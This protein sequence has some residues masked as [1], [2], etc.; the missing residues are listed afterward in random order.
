METVK[1]APSRLGIL[2]GTFDPIHVG[3]LVAASE[4]MHHFGL[5][6]VVLV[7]AG[8]PWQKSEFSD[9]EDRLMM[10][11][12]ASATHPRLSVSRL[13]IDRKGPTYTVDTLEALRSG[14]P[15]AELFLIVGADVAIELKTWHR[16]GDVASLATV[17]A[18][19]RSG[20]DLTSLPTAPGLPDVQVMEMPALD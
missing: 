19:T 4:A 9:A 11:T 3:H 17:I 1:E 10:T 18:V 16:V 13:E 14:F 2:G 12:L 5:E 20:S 15:G 6:R 8:R 7:P